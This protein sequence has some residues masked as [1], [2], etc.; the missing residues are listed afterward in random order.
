MKKLLFSLLA[1]AAMTS[2]AQEYFPNNDDISAVSSA[3]RAI[4][5]ATI[6]TAPGKK[7]ENASILIKD[8]KIVEIGKNIKIPKNA[9][10]EDATGTFIYPS[11]IEAYGDFG[12][13][14]PSRTSRG[15]QQYDEGRKGFYWNDHIRPEQNAIDFYEYDEKAAKSM[16]EAG[17]GTVQTHLHDGIARGTGML[18]ALNT[19][20][21]DSGRVLKN[22][23]GAYYSFDRSS[24]TN[25][26]Y[27]TSLMGTLALLRQAHFDAD[28]YAKGKSKTK[29]RSLEALNNTKNMVQYIEA[30]DKKNILRADK[31]GDRVGKQ[32]I[33]VGGMDA[34][35]MIDDI[36]A[37]NAQLILPMDF[38]D[39]YDV[40]NPYQEWYIN[41]STMRDWKQGPANPMMLQKAGINYAITTHGLKSPGDLKEKLMRAMEYGLTA[42]Q[43][44]AALTTVPAKMLQ[45]DAM[46]GTLEKGKLANFIVTSGE[47][48]D[49]DTD[50]YENWVQGSKHQLKDRSILNVDGTY[51]TSL[52]GENYTMTISGDSKS[53]V[54]KQDSTK[55]GSKISRNGDWITVTTTQKDTTD[56]SYNRWNAKLGPDN[57]MISGKV[58][59]ADGTERNFTARKTTTDEKSEDDKKDDED[60]DE[61][62]A[63]KEMGP[64]TYPNVAFGSITKPVAET[65]LYKNAT[66][67][68][69]EADGILENTDVL[70]KNGKISKVG[71]NLGAGGAR[72]IDATGMH[73]TSGII[74]EH[75]HI[76]IDGG[77]NEAGHNSTAEVTIEDVVDHEDINLYRDLAGG[78]TTSQLLHGSANPIGGRSAIIKL[79]W[80]YKPDEMIYNNSPKFIKFALGENVKQSR[81][82][83]GVRFPQT[84]MG[85]EQVF[86][87]YFTRGQAY[88]KSRGTDD[89]RYD[90]EM[91]VISEILKGERYVSCHSYV[92]SEINMMMEVAERYGFVLNTFTHILE[93]YKVADK[94]AEHGAGGSTFSDWWAY[95]YEVLD[96]I[97]YNGAIMHSQGVVTAFNS[98]DAEMS[99]RLNQEAAKAVKYG[100][101]SEE[102]AWKFVTLN[103]AK[104]LHIDDRTGSIKEGKDADLVLWNTNPLDIQATAQMT[105]IDGAVFFDIKKDEQMRAAVKK[106]RQQ[107]VNEMIM[108][109]NKGLKTQAPKQAVKTLYD[110]DTIE[111]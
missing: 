21:D 12:M 10:V 82:D 2:H 53:V 35:E 103:P 61:D 11:F 55:L 77:V 42:D 101:V 49:K 62:M 41:L 83:N 94:M 29:D 20:G 91:E 40:T 32:F 90:E 36:K 66:V 95:K 4:T 93:G 22:S 63:M 76:G 110:C 80:G 69:N 45:A 89:F 27:P 56:K 14:K 111:W 44:L 51:T 8:G 48:F 86:E 57:S 60:K 87:D 96:A 26:S 5:N 9:L 70:V 16:M 68:T 67:W 72:V 92:Q 58:Y 75:S 64:L 109:K 30:G 98:D 59:L 65:I 34:Y 37:T 107:L 15:G 81:Y 97:P 33:I 85:V 78:V 38:E 18:V 74:D 99:R 31:L 54:V 6:I 13:E 39:A 73:L 104:L 3:S 100:D 79:K 25:Q 7:I 47:L 43:A 17:Y 24:Q 105:M 102:E 84:R 71:S 23:N 1:V 106:E 46:I 108:A 50:I 52:N 19:N 28:W 88:D